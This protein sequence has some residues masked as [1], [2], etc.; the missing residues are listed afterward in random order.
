[1]VVSFHSLFWCTMYCIEL[2]CLV[3]SCLV[4]VLIF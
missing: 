3:L 2:S 1:V 4:F